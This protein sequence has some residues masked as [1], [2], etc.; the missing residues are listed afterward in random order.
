MV[1]EI[2]IAGVQ[3]QRAGRSA[4]DRHLAVVDPNLAHDPAKVFKGVLVAAEKMFQRFGQRELQIELAAERQHHEEKGQAPARR[5]H[6]HRTSTAPVHLG[7]FS[8]FEV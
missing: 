4:Q 7:A 8:G 2:Q 3:H 1:G 6:R 5:A